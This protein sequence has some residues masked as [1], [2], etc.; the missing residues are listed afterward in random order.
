MPVVPPRPW[1]FTPTAGLPVIRAY[2]LADLALS[3]R[4]NDRLRFYVALAQLATV[5][6][7]EREETTPSAFAVL[8][9]F[10]I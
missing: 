2:W 10:Q 9:N 4:T 7:R 6:S 8:R 1:P 5:N 3:L